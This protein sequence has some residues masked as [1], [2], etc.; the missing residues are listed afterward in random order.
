MEFKLRSLSAAD[1]NSEPDSSF[2]I[3]TRPVIE[4]SQVEADDS[5]FAK[6][7]RSYGTETLTLLAR[8]P[9]TIFAFWDIDWNAALR[10]LP[11]KTRA[12]HL[13]L[14]DIDGVEAS[15]V[16]IE[17]MAGSCY[18]EVGEADATYSGE[19]GYFH[20]AT[21]WNCL[22]TSELVTTPAAEFSTETEVD[23][24]TVPFHLS[25]Q[26]MVDLL[27]TTQAENANLTAMLADL[28]ARVQTAETP[29]N[30]TS[31]Q[32]E[33]ART[34]EH[35]ASTTPFARTP[36]DPRLQRKLERVLGFGS[37]S[38][39]GGFGGPSSR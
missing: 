19:I 6:L 23:F 27:Q 38:P 7:P 17:P 5:G 21:K 14:L 2:Q 12:V 34:V 29:N 37:S 3:S 22:A 39:S 24:A 15:M 32:R 28:R 30:I 33:L 4:R 9:H 26:R 35:V 25:F 1:E 8:D 13:R 18:I 11:P 20:P 36:A 31:A 16:E 10:G